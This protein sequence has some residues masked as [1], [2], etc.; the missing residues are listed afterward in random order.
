MYKKMARQRPLIRVCFAGRSVR[1]GGVDRGIVTRMSESSLGIT[2]PRGFSAA[3]MAAGI[4]PSG[5]P[6][7]ALIVCDRSCY[8]VGV[9]TQSATPSAPVVLGRQRLGDTAR[10][11]AILINAGVA[12]AA[13]G[14]RGMDNARRCA[15]LAAEALTAAGR[16][17]DAEAVLPS[18]TGIIGRH[19]PMDKIAAAMPE[20]VSR[21]VEGGRGT[22][23]DADAAR[24]IMTTD[25][26]PKQAGRRLVLNGRE[27]TLAGITK[28]S[29]MIAP[30]MA[31][32][33]AF[34]TTDADIA[35]GPLRLALADAAAASFNRMSVD[36]HTS[37]SDTLIALANPGDTEGDGTPI[38]YTT[39][40]GYEE[41]REAL[42][43]LCRDLA[44]QIVRD[45][46]GATRVFR[47][48][49]VGA[50]SEADADHIGRAVVDS[51]LVKCAVHGRDPNWGRI[52]TAAGNARAAMDE[53]KLSLTIAGGEDATTTGEQIC[54]YRG[55]TPVEPTPADTT[56]L[57]E[58]MASR[59][60]V[61]TLDLGLSEQ[62]PTVDWL[63]C[64]L[65]YDYVRINAEYTT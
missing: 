22:E 57:A 30:N 7:L 51:P 29:G 56:R 1:T 6:D 52:V 47:V 53:S 65:S 10:A 49:V 23:A 3:G 5:K 60:V 48:R 38:S 36:A 20:L 46:E 54:V 21:L 26:V 32:M 42:I 55:G 28:G 8:A 40:A 24:A 18:S 12:N 64:D 2:S 39:D 19:L 31:T 33:L 59:E 9:F 34:I 35:P 63:G 62:T 43:D 41:F 11:Q 45:G 4:K 17:V 14:Q 58:A 27:V 25:L 16:A 15:Q 37:P 61:F 44:Y 50:A 13:T